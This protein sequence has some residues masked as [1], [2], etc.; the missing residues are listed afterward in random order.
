VASRGDRKS[1]SIGVE[2][3]KFVNDVLSLNKPTAIIVESGSIVNLPWLSH[4]NRKQATI[5]A[6][7][8]GQRVGTALGKL[9]FGEAN[10]SGKMPLAWPRE[11]ALIPFVIGGLSMSMDYFFG[12]RSYDDRGVSADLVF[13][14]GWGMSYT[15]FTYSN[16]TALNPSCESAGKR[17]VV[18]Y[19]VDVTNAGAVD[20]EEVVMLFVKGPPKPPGITGNRPVKEL[21]S[22]AKVRLAAGQTS[23]VQLPLAIEDLRHWEG[24]AN[25]KY[26]VD[27]GVYDIMVGPNASESALKLTAQLTV[28]D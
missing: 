28:H 13:P 18:T 26:V 3:E 2:Q 19:A 27:N 9:L 1:L 5:W 15:Q 12:Y 7:Y 17:N 24:D 11:S 8:G 21:K 10:F 4:A 23:T 14:F 25:G 16:L 6:G 22:F 20:G